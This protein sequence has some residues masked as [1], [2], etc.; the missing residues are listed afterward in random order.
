MRFSDSDFEHFHPKVPKK[1]F[2]I[3]DLGGLNLDNLPDFAEDLGL[4]FGGIESLAGDAAKVIPSEEQFLAVF[5]SL[6]EYVEGEFKADGARSMV[7]TISMLV[8]KA[9]DADP[10]LIAVGVMNKDFNEKQIRRRA[11][12]EIGEE[13]WH[14]K[15][16]PMAVYLASPV[17]MTIIPNPSGKEPTPEEMEEILSKIDQYE[18]KDG[19]G[20]VGMSV[21]KKLVRGSF[22]NLELDE[23]GHLKPAIFGDQ[24]S[25]GMDMSLLDYFWMGFFKQTMGRLQD[26]VKNSIKKRSE[27][28]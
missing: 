23:E 12:F 7:P 6:L 2:P 28:N 18:T 26:V 27:N 3:E 14:R 1:G 15:Y 10:E 22:L 24:N 25:V 13:C 16:F 5:D 17:N 11:L 19:L 21:N 8:K 20:V 9:P 4:S